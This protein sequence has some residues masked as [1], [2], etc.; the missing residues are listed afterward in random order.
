MKKDKMMLFAEWPQS[1]DKQHHF[2]R[3]KFLDYF[4]LA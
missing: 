1:F 2:V 4:M 3:S